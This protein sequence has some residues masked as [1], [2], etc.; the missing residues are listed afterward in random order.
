MQFGLLLR[1]LLALALV[2]KYAWILTRDCIFFF[3]S[4]SFYNW[5]VASRARR[6]DRVAAFDHRD[7]SR[8]LRRPTRWPNKINLHLFH[9]VHRVIYLRV[10]ARVSEEV[11]RRPKKFICSIKPARIY[12][13]A[14]RC[15]VSIDSSRLQPSSSNLSFLSFFFFSFKALSISLCSTLGYGDDVRIVLDFENSLQED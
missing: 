12:R 13:S 7:L 9:F 3:S 1:R 14:N 15:R 2:Y 6:A 10:S 4:R 5:Y 11:E 8:R